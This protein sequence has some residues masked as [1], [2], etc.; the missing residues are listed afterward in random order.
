MSLDLQCDLG[1]IGSDD[2]RQD[3]ELQLDSPAEQDGPVDGYLEL[4]P[5]SSGRSAVKRSPKLLT[6]MVRPE[7]IISTRA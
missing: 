1:S 6:S 5:V 2:Y 4:L 7:P 3:D